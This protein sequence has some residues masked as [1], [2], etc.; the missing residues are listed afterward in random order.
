MKN[1]YKLLIGVLALST[2]TSCDDY[3]EVDHYD[4]LPADFMFKTEENVLSGLNG[5][6]DTFYTDQHGS[7]DDETWG[8]KPQVFAAN[9]STMDCQ[10]SGWDAEWQRHAWKPDK[11]SLETAWRMSY[12]AV[13]RANRFLAG[14]ET[15][16]AS[17]FA[18]SNSKTVYE[19]QARAIRGYNYLYLTKLFGR[20]P[21]LLT[22]ETYTTSVGKARPESVDETYAAIEEDL[23]T[24][25]NIR[26][27]FL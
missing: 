18:D 14:L 24:V 3:L 27:L 5:L 6:Y 16:D 19:A 12:R 21:M 26:G 11:G 25:A 1:L 10:A 13:D 7:G 22:G 4:I 9:H 2:V 17:I 23:G 20:V 15:A 8:F